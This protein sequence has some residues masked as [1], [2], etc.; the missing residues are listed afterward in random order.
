[1]KADLP[2]R[3]HI[4]A[5]IA[6]NDGSVTLYLDA[7]CHFTPGQFLMVWIPGV[8]EKPFSIAGRHFEGLMI[9]VKRRGAFSSKLAN[10]GVGGTLGV[11]GPYGQGFRL[12]ENCCLVAGGCGFASLAPIAELFPNAPI[13]YGENSA[14]DLIYRERFPRATVYTGD[15]SAGRKGFPTDDLASLV[16]ERH[17]EMVYCCG[18]EP[19][20][21]KALQICHSEGISCQAS[22]ERYMKCAQ[23]ICGQ[24]ACGSIRVCTEGPVFDG[25]VLLSSPDF[26]KRALDASGTWKPLL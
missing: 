23:G 4:L 19:M 10:L 13:L 17:C 24:C 14:A 7:K 22:V 20:L 2:K 12:V 5:R 21:A 8:N 9:T 3:A 1:M 6:E 26:G 11:R 15:G 18:P 16:R 25:A